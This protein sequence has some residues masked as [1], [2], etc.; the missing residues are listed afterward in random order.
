MLKIKK[1]IKSWGLDINRVTL[2]DMSETFM[3]NRDGAEKEL[4]NTCNG[5][6]VFAEAGLP[7]AR[8]RVA[9][10]TLNERLLR[11]R[12]PHHGGYMSRAESVGLRKDKPDGPDLED[13]E[14]WW[15]RFCKVYDHLVPIAEETDI[16][17]AIHPSDTPLPDTGLGG[18]GFHRVIDAYS[19]CHGSYLY[20]CGTRAEAGGSAIVLDEINN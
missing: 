3:E 7:I 4:E 6:R 5:L 2:P 13:L 1:Q 9:G 11:Y 17:L 8:Q 20:C 10:S 15:D 12:A 18:L 16:R 19:S 14:T